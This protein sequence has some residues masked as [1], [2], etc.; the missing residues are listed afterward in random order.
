MIR[1]VLKAFVLLLGYYGLDKSKTFVKLLTIWSTEW[2][3]NPRILVLQT[4]ALAT[5][6]SV[7]VKS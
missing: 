5:S 3:S 1:A 2:G 4:S 6:P 7:L